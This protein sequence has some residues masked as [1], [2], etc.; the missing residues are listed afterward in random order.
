MGGGWPATDHQGYYTGGGLS[1]FSDL[2][3]AYAYGPNDAH[4]S[5]EVFRVGVPFTTIEARMR[6]H[7]EG[8][9]VI[10]AEPGIGEKASAHWRGEGVL[11]NPLL[12]AVPIWIV[13]GFISP[14]L[15]KWDRGIK[16]RTWA[17][18]WMCTGCGY[19]VQELPICPEC[20]LKNIPTGS[21]EKPENFDRGL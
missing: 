11:F 15:N 14:T 19:D 16:Y 7:T 1:D 8:G 20:G 3:I 18:R 2:T 4:Y 5:M 6:R 10:L 12:I 13:I 9:V 17:K 21:R